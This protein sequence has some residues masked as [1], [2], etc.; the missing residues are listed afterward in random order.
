MIIIKPCPFCGNKDLAFVN[1]SPQENE[2]YIYFVKRFAIH[3]RY[4]G[5]AQGCGTESGH[6]KSKDEAIEAWNKRVSDEQS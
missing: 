1:Y 2:V 6:Y 5:E 3:C 4:T